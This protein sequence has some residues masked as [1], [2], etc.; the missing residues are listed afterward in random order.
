MTTA[1]LPLAGVRVLETADKAEMCGRYLADLGATVIKVE[2]RA[3][4]STRR[5]GPFHG[6]RSISFAIQN[7][8]KRGVVLDVEH[9]EDRAEFWRVLGTADLWITSGSLEALDAAGLSV[10]L[11]RTRYPRLVVLSVTDFGLTGPSPSRSTVRRRLRPP[12][13]A[14][15]AA[16]AGDARLARRPG[17]PDGR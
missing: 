3:G 17:C 11:V 15:R 2:P 14:Q 7:A 10:S 8:N 12:R 9:Q 16:V 6:G 4:A 5:N 13:T 1:G